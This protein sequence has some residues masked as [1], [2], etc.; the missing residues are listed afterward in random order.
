MKNLDRHLI[1]NHL[2]APGQREVMDVSVRRQLF[3]LCAGL[4]L[5]LPAFAQQHYFQN[6]SV[7]EGLPQ[8]QVNGICQDALGRMWFATLSGISCFDGRNFQNYSQKDGLAS[9]ITTEIL[10]D[11]RGQIW[12]GTNRGL[13]VFDGKRF[14]TYASNNAKNQ[15]NALV[16]DHEGKIWA[17]F[18]GKLHYIEAGKLEACEKAPFDKFL[19]QSLFCDEKGRLWAAGLGYDGVVL[20]KNGESWTHI[21]IHHEN[22]AKKLRAR[23][24]F[25]DSKQRVWLLTNKGVFR[26]E[27][28]GFRLFQQFQADQVIEKNAVSMCE[29]FKGQLWFVGLQG[30]FVLDDKGVQQFSATNGFSNSLTTKAFPDREGN[31]WFSTDGQGV[32]KYKGGAFIHFDESNGLGHPIVMSLLRDKQGL[33]WMG[34]YGG[35]LQIYDGKK[36]ITRWLPSDNAAS[37][38]IVPMIRDAG[39][40]LWIGTN[41]GGLW[42]YDGRQFSQFAKNDTLL[43]AN[44]S[45]LYEDRRGRIWISTNKGIAI[46]EGG[47]L[48]PW[49]PGKP[50]KNIALTGFLGLEKDSMII[51]CDQGLWLWDG[52]KLN[53]LFDG[54]VL[55]NSAILC[56][57]R[58]RHRVWVGT[59]GSGLVCWSRTANGKDSVQYFSKKEGLSSEIIYSLAFDRKGQ[60]WVGT[61]NGINRIQYSNNAIRVKTYGKTDGVLGIETNQNAILAEP[62]GNIWFGTTKGLCRY[63]PESE[64]RKPIAFKALL[65]S[66]ELFSDTIPASKLTDS[67][68]AWYNIPVGLR[69]GHRQ[70]HLTFEFTCVPIADP[71]TVKFR[72][73]LMG[74]DEQV[75]ATTANRYVVY[76]DLPPGKYEFKVWAGDDDTG[77]VTEPATMAFEI[78]PPFY[79]KEWFQLLVVGVLIGIGALIQYVRAR[80]KTQRELEMERLRKDEQDKVR[81]RVA[82]DFH[83]ELGNKLTRISVLTEVLQ[84]K[85][86]G[87]TPEIKKIIGQMRENS[88]A[89]YSGT[90]DILWSLHPDSDNLYE[91]LKRLSDF[92]T[93]LF[94]DTE[95]EFAARGLDE[96]TLTPY[97]LPMDYSRNLM[98]IFKEALHNTLKHAHARQVNMTIELTGEQIAITLEDNGQGFDQAALPR[99]GQGLGNMQIRARR[100]HAHLEVQ[101]APLEGTKVA[102]RFD[103]PEA[104]ATGHAFLQARSKS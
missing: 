43:G 89:L 58:D 33:L 77:F 75:S 101:S 103:M 93:E 55:G 24:I 36:I 23:E 61:G 50:L 14:Q 11:Q 90:K 35:G 34:T 69:L 85:L 65:T 45:G 29:D 41:G 94:E 3:S 46:A 10:A 52:K 27:A 71:G 49:A 83:D 56:L 20:Q 70:N 97:R 17:A 32:F 87:T 60:L 81:R 63:N 48:K 51:A 44:I 79:Q 25:V 72:Y 86:N 102:L 67:L 15:V 96:E 80:W 18:N 30:V 74:L 28:D 82:E 22:P 12:A 100:I 1:R 13:S 53:R 95:T 2:L 31:L 64:T 62:N 91:I 98:M 68:T 84:A 21:P 57:A 88:A 47:V 9:N 7:E 40:D 73:Q 19:V 6:F 16:E 78:I 76:P 4:L 8:M 39:G 54:E 59:N 92:G 99:K 42:R 5:C 104:P 37:R 66:V 38:R 26:L